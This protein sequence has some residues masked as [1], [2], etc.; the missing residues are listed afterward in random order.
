MNNFPH[1]VL[2]QDAGTREGLGV[3]DRS[4]HI[5]IIHAPVI[6]EGLIELVHAGRLGEHGL[7]ARGVTYRGSVLPVNRPP[8]SLALVGWSDM[9]LGGG[10]RPAYTKR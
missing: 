9:A 5:G 8:H 6:L 7:A 4:P 2:R 1:F 10:R 3:G